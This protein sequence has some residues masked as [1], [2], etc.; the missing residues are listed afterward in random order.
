MYLKSQTVGQRINYSTFTRLVIKR[1]IIE[2]IKYERK[3]PNFQ[4]AKARKVRQ[5][6][7]AKSKQALPPPP[8]L[9]PEQVPSFEGRQPEISVEQ[10]PLVP[11][12]VAME[13]GE[14][15]HIQVKA[16]DLIKL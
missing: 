11:F 6:P 7:K 16:F 8:P 5:N 10:Q 13:H 1:F 3:E 15:P 2:S 4:V 9:Q 12:A 14:L